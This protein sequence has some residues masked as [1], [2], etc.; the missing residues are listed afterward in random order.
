MASALKKMLFTAQGLCS[1][2]AGKIMDAVIE[3][4]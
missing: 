4:S 1:A 2:D 3:V